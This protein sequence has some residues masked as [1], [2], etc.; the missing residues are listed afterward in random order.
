MFLDRNLRSFY[1]CICSFVTGISDNWQ[2][3]RHV[4][5]EAYV[6]R[7]LR[8]PSDLEIKKICL[9][10]EPIKLKAMKKKL[11]RFQKI[12]KL[13]MLW[14][15][16]S[17]NHLQGEGLRKVGRKMW[18]AEKSSSQKILAWP[19]PSHPLHVSYF[20]F[21]AEF[22]TIWHCSPTLLY[23]SVSPQEGKLRESWD[24]ALLSAALSPGFWTKAGS[25]QQIL[26]KSE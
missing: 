14:I 12:T 8:M 17:I 4:G 15:L 10:S 16:L 19:T 3:A 20:I 5:E 1:F 11:V 2:Y 9:L 24:F 7:L 23:W 21:I 25:V 18:S 13:T 22:T 26:S 6:K